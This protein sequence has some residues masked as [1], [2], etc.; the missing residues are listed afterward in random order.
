M[1]Y[2]MRYLNILMKNK[3]SVLEVSHSDSAGEIFNGYSLMHAI[4]DKDDDI[5]CK[6]LVKNKAH[7]DSIKIDITNYD[8]QMQLVAM[9]EN[10]SSQNIVSP[11]VNLITNSTEWN[12]ADVINYQ[13][14]RG[15][16]I[17]VFDM[18]KLFA[19][20]TIWTIHNCWPFTGGCLHPIECN[21]WRRGGCTSCNRNDN[22]KHS[23]L[24]F[25]AE[26]Y[27]KKK[28]C[29]RNTD[30]PIVVSSNYMKKMV[31]NN[32]ILNN[33]PISV[34]PFGIVE[35]IVS[36]KEIDLF[37]KKNGISRSS[38]I[39]VGFRNN[40]EFIK[41]CKYLYEALEGIN[42]EICIISVGGGMIPP[43][44]TEKFE[45]YSLAWLSNEDM[46]CFY[47][48]CS[49]FVMPSLAESFGM[50]AIE[51]MIH[52]TPVISFEN[53][54][55]AELVS[56]PD[57]GLT[58]KYGDSTDLRRVLLKLIDNDEERR[59]RGC[60]SRDI[61]LDKYNFS[62]YVNGYEKIYRSL[63]YLNK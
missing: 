51:A 32:S 56:H 12:K 28:D 44:I 49:I 41:G 14:M 61:V 6:M 15:F 33:H 39:I 17:S 26:E 37:C 2:F 8:L 53:T 23:K 48:L 19:K 63:L 58:C 50:M 36:K 1:I 16:P 60:K 7:D 22:S 24:S 46:N 5:E 55:N 42:R 20:K 47:E 11:W 31:E 52:K 10:L 43:K 35:T 21:K 54:A 9:G 38:K 34:I 30:F 45:C 59:I 18:N 57:C 27:E 62:N 29:Y 4:N 25:S 40:N 13:L 3:I